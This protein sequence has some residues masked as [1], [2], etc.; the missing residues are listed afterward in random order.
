MSTT[1]R[2]KIRRATPADLREVLELARRAL[3]WGDPDPSFLEWKHLE[4]A[5][6]A[7]PMWLALG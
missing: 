5:F 7:S 1:D 2:V 4:N 3:G 6:G